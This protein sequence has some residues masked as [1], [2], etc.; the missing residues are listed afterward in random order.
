VG[1]EPWLAALRAEG[2]ERLQSGGW[3]KLW[4]HLYPEQLMV[5]DQLEDQGGYLGEWVL[6]AFRTLLSS[7]PPT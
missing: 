5:R 7:E 4:R 6:D 3:W 2:F 1:N